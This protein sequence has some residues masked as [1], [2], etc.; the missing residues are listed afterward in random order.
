MSQARALFITLEGGEGCGKSTQIALL[1]QRLQAQGR[2][3]TLLREPGGTRIGEAIRAILLDPQNTALVPMAE[4]MLYEAARAQLVAERI[5]PALK[6]GG[7]V[8]CDRFYD[9][10]AAYQG[11]GRGFN[12]DTLTHL[13]QFATGGLA[14][15]LTIII[16]LPVAA[17]LKRAAGREAAD[18]LE[19]EDT[20]F[21][22]RVRA[23]FLEIAR[24][25]PGR[26]HVVDGAGTPETV[27]AQIAR[28]V[29]AL[30]LEQHP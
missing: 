8:L 20:A 30:L 12:M 10:T 2:P 6:N 17:G 29:D 22:E 11:G 5:N 28:R 14:P 21:H 18:R 19:Q 16:D 15:D 7:I 3:V 4:L 27:A 1:Q 9:S 13:N 24:N 26:V 25:E 23:A